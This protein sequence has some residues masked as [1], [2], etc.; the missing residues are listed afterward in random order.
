MFT[1]NKKDS[2]FSSTTTADIFLCRQ[3]SI[4]TE[5]ACLSDEQI[6]NTDFDKL[7]EYYLG[8]YKILPIELLLD[9]ITKEISKIVIKESDISVIDEPITR[10]IDGVR[11]SLTIPFTGDHNLLLSRPS[12]YNPYIV[13]RYPYDKIL[14]CTNS[15]CG[16]ILISLEFTLEALQREPPT[17]FD[18]IP[19]KDFLE[20]ITSI[21]ADVAKHNESLPSFI[22]TALRDRKQKAD[23][24]VDISKKFSIPLRHNTDAPNVVPISLKKVSDKKP[25]MPSMRQNEIDYAISQKDYEN[26]CRIIALAGLS[27]ETAART[28]VKLDEEEL[29]DIIIAFLNTHY[30]GTATGETFSKTGKTDIRIPFDNKAAYIAECKI[31][32]GIKSFQDAWSQLFGYTTWRDVKTSII[33]FNKSNKGFGIILDTIATYLANGKTH[34]I[35][36]KK[37]NE[38]LCEITK[39]GET[40]HNVSVQVIVFDICIS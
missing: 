24:Y 23:V 10:D 26:I 30:L 40:D 31:W 28:F 17:F 20:I 19:G 27:M 6:L 14:E 3:G 1:N 9:S 35:K 32:H 12:P 37:Q 2:L 34:K 38:W 11:V 8:E 13:S 18:G 36:R 15:S 25:E 5:I 39:D 7:I 16:S 33:L 29:R 22:E 21:N 4:V